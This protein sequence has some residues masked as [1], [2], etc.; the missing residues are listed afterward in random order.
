MIG[1][2]ALVLDMFGAELVAVPVVDGAGFSCT[3]WVR[4]ERR[5]VP[6]AAS[7][8]SPRPPCPQGRSGPVFVPESREG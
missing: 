6:P 2:G 3:F 4:R 7:F 8:W 1:R 5:L